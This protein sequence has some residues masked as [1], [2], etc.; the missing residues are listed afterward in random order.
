MVFSPPLEDGAVDI[1]F[2]AQRGLKLDDAA[3]SARAGVPL[4]A[5]RAFR[6]AGGGDE[7]VVVA[8]ADALGLKAG[9]LVALARGDY[10]PAPIREIEG[11]RAFNT[12]FDD[13]TVNSYLVWDPE[14][15]EAAMFDT[16]ADG[17]GMLDFA[18]G[19][20]LSVK[21]I[22]LT[23]THTDHIFD[24]DRLLE[25]TG[26]HAW[27]GEREAMSGAESFAVGRGFKIG[28]LTV[29]TR[30]TCG[31]SKG[32]VTYFIKG[33]SKPVAVVGDAVF[34]GSMGGGM[35]SYEEALRTNRA[36]ILTLPDNTILCPGHG[37]L[38]T[39]GEQKTSNPFLAV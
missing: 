4:E 19:R 34:A 36:E 13:M 38:T 6:E 23:H 20:G 33:L 2:K 18:A 1:V 14:T 27:V 17:Q 12:P 39:V 29:E 21:S 7:A 8:L 24:L 15:L 25:K 26:A 31:H 16:G 22:F 3:L 30:S 11:L 10:R 32:G 37:P 9:A 5:I 28:W 35:V